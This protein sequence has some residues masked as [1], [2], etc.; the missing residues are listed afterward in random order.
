MIREGV[1]QFSR[2]VEVPKKTLDSNCSEQVKH[3]TIWQ[4]DKDIVLSIL[5]QTVAVSLEA[6]LVGLDRDSLF[7]ALSGSDNATRIMW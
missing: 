5:A 3:P 6:G 7:S 1:E 2:P 4:P